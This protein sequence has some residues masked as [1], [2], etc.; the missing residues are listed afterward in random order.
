M[1]IYIIIII[2]TIIIVIVIIIFIVIIIKILY[3]YRIYNIIY[4]IYRMCIYIYILC[5]LCTFYLYIYIYIYIEMLNV[6]TK[7]CD[8]T[9]KSLIYIQYQGFDRLVLDIIGA[10]TQPCAWF[11]REIAATYGSQT[12]PT[13]IFFVGFLFFHWPQLTQLKCLFL[14]TASS[15]KVRYGVSFAWS[16]F[17]FNDSLSKEV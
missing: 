3:I 13:P 1:Y 12:V 6:Y 2:I 7:T 11:K 14:H 15:F 16:C 17:M 8:D 9:R 10:W 5:Y 4:Y